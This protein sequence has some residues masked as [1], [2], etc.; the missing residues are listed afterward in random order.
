MVVVFGL[1][2]AILYGSADF[3]GGA[4]SR[5]ARVLSVLTASA[6]AG[7]IIILA[8]AL[9][10]GGPARAAGLG[11]AAAAGVAGGAGLIGLYA[12]LAAGPMTVVAPV[13]ALVS[14]VLPVSVA[15][16]SGEHPGPKVYLGALICLL[17]IV[18]VSMEGAAPR[19]PAGHAGAARGIG[20]GVASGIAFG[21]F[22]LFLRDAGASGVLWPAAAARLSGVVIMIGAAAWMGAPPAWRGMS[23][24]VLLAAAASGVFDAGANICYILATRAGLFGIAVVLTSLGPGATVL[25]ARVLLGERMRPAQ[26]AGLCLAGIG[27]VLV[28]A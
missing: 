27:I 8:A 6:P 11:W 23:G 15:L 4:A 10:F 26:R 14:T 3:L 17:A 20:C 2:A 12:G 5:R 24:P 25:L 9:V 21:L 18:L 7:A 13:C 19:R 1:A 16:A 22:F 28:T